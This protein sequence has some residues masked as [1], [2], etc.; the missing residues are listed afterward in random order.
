MKPTSALIL[1]GFRHS[2]RSRAAV[3]IF[4]AIAGMILALLIYLAVR[5]W[6]G[7]GAP[8]APAS[9]DSADHFMGLLVYS[10]SLVILGLNL[11]GFSAQA[12]A[13]EKSQRII[14]TILASPIRPRTLWAGKVLAVF[15][16]GFVM[17]TIISLAVGLVVALT[18]PHVDVSILAHG[19]VLLDGFVWIPLVY[20]GIAALSQAIGFVG[21]PVLANVVPQIFLP[22]SATTI[23][24][25][26]ARST[27]LTNS[28]LFHAVNGA[29]AL[30]LMGAALLVVRGLTA[31]RI[32]RSKGA[33]S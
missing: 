10:T 33:S 24:N 8:A 30:L 31:E 3:L 26:G 13:R 15:L 18:S 21:S 4:S 23:I 12:L 9:V 11:N 2:Y 25:L 1:S 7:A 22:V 5:F 32:V 20:L 16:P 28:M 14:E 17:S 27:L 19:S 29:V 6:F